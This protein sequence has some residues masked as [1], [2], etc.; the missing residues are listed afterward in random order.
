MALLACSEA[1]SRCT[2]T[3]GK[4]L[5]ALLVALQEHPWQEMMTPQIVSMLLAEME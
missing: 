5:M 4:K 3:L 2:S 1:S